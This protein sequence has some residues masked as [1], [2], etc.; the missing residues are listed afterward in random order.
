METVTIFHAWV[1][2]N[3]GGRSHLTARSHDEIWAKI[4]DGIAR[5]LW[6]SVTEVEES[7]GVDWEAENR[8][9]KEYMKR[10]RTEPDPLP[11]A[12]TILLEEANALAPEDYGKIDPNAACYR[13]TRDE[14]H[15]IRSAKYNEYLK[16]FRSP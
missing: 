9:F 11:E 3:C 16:R 8:K 10:R 1:V 4:E 15:R 6:A 5:G 13:V 7:R 2:N 14:L 12:D